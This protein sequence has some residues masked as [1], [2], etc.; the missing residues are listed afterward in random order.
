MCLFGGEECAIDLGHER[1]VD[2]FVQKDLQ[3]IVMI[4]FA[5]FFLRK[6]KNIYI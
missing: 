5:L 2:V 4:T 1:L 6:K 3:S